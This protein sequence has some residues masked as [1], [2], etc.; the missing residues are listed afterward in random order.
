MLNPEWLHFENHAQKAFFT[1]Y[2]G[3]YLY[4]MPV[5]TNNISYPI[6]RR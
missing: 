5:L 4:G 3:M 1:T 2:A 6:E